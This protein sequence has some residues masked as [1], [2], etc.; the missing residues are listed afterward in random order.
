MKNTTYIETCLEFDTVIHFHKKGTVSYT[1]KKKALC[2]KRGC[3]IGPQNQRFCLKK[4]CFFVQNPRKG[5][6]FSNLATS[7]LYTSGREW[8][9]RIPIS[10]DTYMYCPRQH[11]IIISLNPKAAMP[12]LA[13]QEATSHGLN[14]PTSHAVSSDFRAESRLAP[15]QWETS[16]QSNAISHWLGANLESALWFDVSLVM[17]HTQLFD[18][19]L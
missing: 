11:N 17:V 5:G 18:L 7:M 3:F 1:T 12:H 15:S 4:G 16:L 19:L 6:V 2:L 13:Q 8:G 9:E 10:V 14:I